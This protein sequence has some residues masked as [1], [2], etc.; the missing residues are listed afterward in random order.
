MLIELLKLRAGCNEEVD[1]EI[2]TKE[3]ERSHH[4]NVA[5]DHN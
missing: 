4:Q 1:L 5:H 2:N 3:N